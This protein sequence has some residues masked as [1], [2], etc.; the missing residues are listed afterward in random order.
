MPRLLEFLKKAV[1]W[2]TLICFYGTTLIA[3]AGQSVWVAPAPSAIQQGGW[4]EH[5]NELRG[6]NRINWIPA[7]KNTRLSG[8]HVINLPRDNYH[9]TARATWTKGKQAFNWDMIDGPEWITKNRPEVG[10][11]GGLPNGVMMSNWITQQPGNGRM[12][13]AMYSPQSL[14]LRIAVQKVEKLPNGDI[15]VAVKD[16]TPHHGRAWILSGGYRTANEK[17]WDPDGLGYNPFQAFAGAEDDPVFNNISWSGAVTAIGLAI[18]HE[19]ALFGWVATSHLRQDTSTSESGNRFRKKVTT[20]T[21]VYVKP[22]WWIAG[23]VEMVIGGQHHS[24]CVGPEAIANPTAGCTDAARVANSGVLIAPW[25]GNNLPAVSEEM[26]YQHVNQQKSW[27]VLFYA[28]LTLLV[29]AGGVT[30]MAAY[31]GMG[32]AGA[33]AVSGSSIGGAGGGAVAWGGAAAG[34]YTAAST[35]LFSHG[36]LTSVQEGYLGSIT[37][38]MASALSSGAHEVRIAQGVNNKLIK[39]AVQSGANL[40]G[41]SQLFGTTCP[42]NLSVAECNAQ[43]LNP[44][45]GWRTDSYMQAREVLML[46]NQYRRCFDGGYRGE[47]LAKCAAPGRTDLLT[48]IGQ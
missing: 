43:G 35:S 18:I 44:G 14:K 41:V 31:G 30:L 11:A 39:P 46:R 48:A 34:V 4:A 38:G 20:T 32:A 36:G 17:M 47:M 10:Q 13:F 16:Y 33:T 21:N 40:S 9:I 24:I 2:I 19:R 1:T 28:V 25:K 6:G 23:P 5:A 3:S 22:N 37:S 12:V 27:T 42:L 7:T 15:I 8:T 29:V 45:T 26:I